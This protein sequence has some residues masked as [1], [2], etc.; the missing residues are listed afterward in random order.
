MQQ[1]HANATTLAA[2]PDSAA[3]HTAAAQPHHSQPF[4]QQL[5]ENT[6]LDSVTLSMRERLLPAAS[7]CNCDVLTFCGVDC[8]LTR[9]PSNTN[10][11]C[12]VAAR[13]QCKVISTLPARYTSSADGQDMQR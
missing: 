2:T 10:L 1:W 7:R 9:C 12:A 3:Q 8:G 6:R 4:V 5:P 13:H 11:H